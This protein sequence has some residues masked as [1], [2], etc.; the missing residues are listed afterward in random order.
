M[1]GPGAAILVDLADGHV[2]DH[3]GD[4]DVDPRVL[5]RQLI[6]GGIATQDEEVWRERFVGRRS[7]DLRRDVGWHERGTGADSDCD[8]MRAESHAA[9]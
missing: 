7:I 8:Q 2:R 1:N 3:A 6:E 4:G 9:R 5:Q